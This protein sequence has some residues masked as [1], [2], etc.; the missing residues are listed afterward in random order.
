MKESLQHIGSCRSIAIQIAIQMVQQLHYMVIYFLFF[1]KQRAL[2]A[3]DALL[4]TD[5]VRNAGFQPSGEKLE[6]KLT[7][8][9]EKGFHSCLLFFLYAAT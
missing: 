5:Y 8:L 6:S 3:K 4:A 9:P 7:R 1:V 2:K